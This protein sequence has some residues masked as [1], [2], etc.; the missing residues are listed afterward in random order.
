MFLHRLKQ[1]FW[2]QKIISLVW[3]LA[4]ILFPISAWSWWVAPFPESGGRH[5]DGSFQG[6]VFLLGGISLAILVVSTMRKDE[7]KGP[8]AFWNTRPIRSVTLFASKWAY[9]QLVTTIPLFIS[10]VV[11]GYLIDRFSDAFPNALEAAAW[12][13]TATTIVSYSVIARP[14]S[15]ILLHVFGL[16]GGGFL[17]AVIVFGIPGLEERITPDFI[18]NSQVVIN[19]LILLGAMALIFGGFFFWQIK[20][21]YFGGK[22]LWMI[23]I[24]AMTVLFLFIAPFSRGVPGTVSGNEL[25]AM[26]TN[27]QPYFSVGTQGKANRL[28]SQSVILLQGDCVIEEEMSVMMLSSNLKIEGEGFDD[29]SL[30]KLEGHPYI[31]SNKPHLQL[32]VTVYDQKPTHGSSSSGSVENEIYERLSRKSYRVTGEVLVNFSY[33]DELLTSSILDDEVLYGDGVQFKCKSLKKSDGDVDVTM[34]LKS[35]HFPVLWDTLGGNRYNDRYRL[36]LD[37]P[38]IGDSAHA[39]HYS[40][41]GGSSGI[42]GR[43]YKHRYNFD[44]FELSEYQLKRARDAGY[45]GSFKDWLGEAKGVVMKPSHNVYHRV[46][47][48]TIIMLPDPEE[49]RELLKDRSLK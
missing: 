42:F 14:G 4:L 12:C 1:E 2:E 5:G 3:L 48:D 15:G 10:M 21:R 31:R 8:S 7:L 27:V 39:N 20:K 37:A 41:G 29:L 36:V 18:M 34:N 11:T 45:E 33:Y 43:H 26:A 47:V 40:S 16:V 28:V 32:E 17:T 30:F 13:F 24:G 49:V 22:A 38:D 19:T 6:L 35:S 46:K 44:D 9:L 23:C 25:T